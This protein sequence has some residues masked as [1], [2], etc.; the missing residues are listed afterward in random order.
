MFKNSTL[1]ADKLCC[2]EFPDDL[3]L[4]LDHHH[5]LP[6]PVYTRHDIGDDIDHGGDGSKNHGKLSLLIGCSRSCA[7]I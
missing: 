2:N 6:V 4:E 5:P 3:C 1:F 7:L